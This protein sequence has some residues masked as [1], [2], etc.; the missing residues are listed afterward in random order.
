M[1]PES[2]NIEFVDPVRERVMSGYPMKPG[3]T[4]QPRRIVYRCREGLLVMFPFWLSHGVQPNRSQDMRLSLAFNI[5]C[6]PKPLQKMK[7]ADINA[8]QAPS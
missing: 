1:P 3:F 6:V 5:D 2:G 8:V 7:P 4:Q